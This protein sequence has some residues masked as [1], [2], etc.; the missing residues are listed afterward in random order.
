M[1]AERSQALGSIT[2]ASAVTSTKVCF[3]LHNILICLHGQ[4]INY[5]LDLILG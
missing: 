1:F 2:K 5:N 3:Y 4:L